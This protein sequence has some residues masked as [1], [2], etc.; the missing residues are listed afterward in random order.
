MAAVRGVNLLQNELEKAKESLKDVDE[1]IRKL[2]GRDPTG[3]RPVR[4]VSIGGSDSRGGKS[5]PGAERIFSLARRGIIKDEPGL[6][7]RGGGAFSRLGPR[8]G[9]RERRGRGQDSGDEE[10]MKPALQSSVI[11]TPKEERSRQVSIEEQ[12]K[13]RKGQARNRR[14]FGLLLGTLQKFKD[15]SKESKEKEEQRIK[16]EKKLDEKFKQEKEDI[17][18]ERRQL[19]QERRKKQFR[20]RLIEQKMEMVKNHENWEVET[21]KLENFIRTKARPHIFY[22]PKIITTDVEAKLIDTKA[23]VDVMIENRRKKMEVE[24]EDLMSQVHDVADD[25]G[26]ASMGDDDDEDGRESGDERS[27]GDGER[28]DDKENR[29]RNRSS[30]EGKDDIF[31]ER[32]QRDKEREQRDRD[33]QFKDMRREERKKG[34]D[35]KDIDDDKGLKRRESERR[36]RSRERRNSRK[37][38]SK[39]RGRSRSGSGSRSRHR[40]ARSRSDRS[41]HYSESSKNTKPKRRSKG[42]SKGDKREKVWEPMEDEEEEEFMGTKDNESS[43]GGNIQSKM[44]Q[45]AGMAKTVAES[46]DG[47]EDPVE[48]SSHSGFVESGD[49]IQDIPNVKEENLND[50]YTSE[51]S[52]LHT[53]DDG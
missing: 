36:E 23:A 18:K 15:E 47:A 6:G 1:N 2:T 29:E 16:I 50:S 40:S 35:G 38:V 49:V 32:E 42:D 33:K 41:R 43:G 19:F 12:S 26:D 53:A 31:T 20:I 3:Q 10:D 52:Q 8:A 17:I 48:E 21:R 39:H 7:R 46:N 34:K 11:A 25:D 37:D 24:I 14:M 22:M 44:L 5:G 9:G 4:R 45:M 28:R 51:S 30:G 27:E 13:D